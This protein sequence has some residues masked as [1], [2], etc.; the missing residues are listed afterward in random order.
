MGKASIVIRKSWPAAVTLLVALGYVAYRLAAVG[1]DPV[2]LAEP[3]ERF[4]QGI[5]QGTEGYDGQF[6]LYVALDPNPKHVADQLDVPAYRY[7]RILLPILARVLGLGQAS[8]IPWTLILVNLL[9]HSAATLA[10]C[11]LLDRYDRWVGYALLYGLWVGSLVG[12]GTDLHEPLAYGLIAWALW[13][14]ARGEHR[15]AIGM[16]I[17]AVFAKE[18]TLVFVAAFVM[19]DWQ[20]GR[21]GRT[22]R[23]Y[24]LLLAAFFLWQGWLWLTFG[25]PGVGS[26][27][28]MATP[29]EWIP[30]MGFLRIA[31]HSLPV[32][33]LY[34]LLF[35]PGIIFPALWGIWHSA[36]D[37]VRNQSTVGTW[38][39]ML[40]GLL[41]M[42][43]PYSTFREPLGLVR[44]ATGLV[45]SIVVAAIVQGMR[46]P[47]T[48]GWF[49]L[50]YLVLGR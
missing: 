41:I 17:A 5:S 46:R 40:H 42:V 1:W 34:L 49:W 47:L 16:S 10:L 3:G 30:L 36:Q 22:R 27:G 12:V 39:L 21:L 14:R 26:G 13:L 18:T 6:A 37:I 23:G 43:T 48:Y 29:F 9:A 35:G 19:A 8:A 20:A 28:L 38:P 15:R 25:Q 44:L 24:G 50:A 11:L 31:A 2:L 32:F 33:L 4:Q 7:Q 45:L